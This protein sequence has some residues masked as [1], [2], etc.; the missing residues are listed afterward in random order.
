VSEDDPVR[1]P[2]AA[3][4]YLRDSKDNLI[5]VELLAKG[6]SA[7]ETVLL[8]YN[9]QLY[10]PRSGNDLVSGGGFRQNSIQLEDQHKK[11][12]AHSKGKGYKTYVLRYQ[13]CLVLKSHGLWNGIF[14]RRSRTNAFSTVK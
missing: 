11:S 2:R 4:K 6:V 12:E 10:P 7:T 1:M 3:Q 14:T 5:I 9:L 8:K 13:N